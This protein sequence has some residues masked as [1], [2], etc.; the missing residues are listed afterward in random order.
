M[1]TFLILLFFVAF[2][3]LAWRKIE[4]GIFV[5]VATLPL[6]VVRFSVFGLPSTL[7]EGMIL[8]LFSVWL[9]QERNKLWEKR[10]ILYE[11]RSFTAIVL[12][13][14]LVSCVAVIIA[15]HTYSALGLWRAYILE[16]MFFFLVFSDTIHTKKQIMRVLIASIVS[17]CS[18]ALYGIFQRM[19][20][21]GIPQEWI[22][23]RR[24]TSIY[25]YPN[26]VGLYLA[27]IVMLSV[28]L[29]VW[30]IN[31]HVRGIR[32]QSILSLLSI[33][34]G[35]LFAGVIF[36]KTESALIALGVSGIFFGLFWSLR[37][38]RVTIAFCI[39][40]VFFI[41]ISPPLAKTLDEKIFLKDWSGLVRKS[42]W[43][44][45]IPMIHNN[46]ILGAGFSGYQE[47]MKS[48]HKD[49]FLE[50]YQYPHN[51]VLNFL[52][53]MGIAGLV[54]FE[55]L[56]GWYFCVLARILFILRKIPKGD[57]KDF[58]R[59][60]TFGCL[61]AMSTIIIHGLVDV[62]YFKND[63]SVFFWVLMG[64]AIAVYTNTQRLSKNVH[65]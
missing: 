64:L 24:I 55:L 18:I 53:E 22:L 48:Y 10:K 27:P 6:Y 63:L 25:P 2:F 16:P 51:I 14:F 46:W 61:F 37:S 28:S 57:E 9:F 44:E 34:M 50:I 38:R 8:V 62:P 30:R 65:I 33:I 60:L 4:Y 5:V 17:G 20:G 23:E 41:T 12:L 19:T 32:E 54:A 1:N 49:T 11:Y 56:V 13:F 42:I 47:K 21:F 3:A 36:A 35:I 26:A 31:T 40:I 59:A 43:R 52:S 58:M 15:P 39:F 45:T 29:L 7:L